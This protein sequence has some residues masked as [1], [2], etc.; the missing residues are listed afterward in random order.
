MTRNALAA[1][2]DRGAR[3]CAIALGFTLPISVALDNVLLVAI[4]VLW[5]VAG[6]WR[7]VHRDVAGNPV[8]LIALALAALHAIGLTYTIA[9]RPEA[10]AGLWNGARLALIAVLIA[11]FRDEATRRRALGA[12]ACAMALTLALSWLVWLDALPQVKWI[13][14]TPGNAI[15][16]KWHIT[17]NLFMALGAYLFALIARE[18][19]SPR[20]R[21]ACAVLAAA[22][23]ANVLVMVQGR[24]GH[25]VVVVLLAWF[26]IAW[27]GARGAAIATAGIAAIAVIA[28]VT[29][30][31]ML[32]S[33]VETAIA[34][35][36]TH[37]PG[38]ATEKSIG[39]RLEFYRRG[40]E[41]LAEHPVLGVGTGGFA[42][43]Y[44]ERAGT[45]GKLPAENPHNEYLSIGT[46]FGTL[47]LALLAALFYAQFRA[48]AAIPD[49]LE[50]DLGRGLAL[51][52][53]TASL[54]S[55]TLMDHAEG[56]LFV[57]LTALVFRD[58]RAG[59]TAA[60]AT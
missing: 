57:W 41:I 47:G 15:V 3:A 49:R 12:F 43:A 51:A 2:A 54:V 13:K 5:L 55:S 20:L 19:R 39:V 24:T 46:Q 29:P 10:L 50:R 7:T 53:A 36:E 14:G 56:L 33:R 6:H 34:E 48:A 25:L 21:W 38:A 27:L 42:A 58:T 18:A 8:V 4:L 59:R 11:L 16:F 44:A 17:H 35:Y 32:K 23:A 45:G 52:F 40:T 1:G 28:W 22:A 9:E 31:N 26:C 60:G 30:G 37:V